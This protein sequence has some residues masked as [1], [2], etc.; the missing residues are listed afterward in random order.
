LDEEDWM[1]EEGRDKE[2]GKIKEKRSRKKD[3]KGDQADYCRRY[4]YK[5]SCRRTQKVDKKDPRSEN[6]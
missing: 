6:L 4:D 5:G 2:K 1:R 3:E